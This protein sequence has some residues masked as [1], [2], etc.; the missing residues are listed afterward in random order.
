MGT[1]QEITLSILQQLEGVEELKW[2]QEKIHKRHK[3][4]FR[5]IINP[6]NPGVP[7]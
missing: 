5:G 4:I 1:R 2:G 3:R 6:D 7:E